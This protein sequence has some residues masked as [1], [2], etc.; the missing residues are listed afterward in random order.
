MIG[1]F[2]LSI[3]IDGMGEF[4]IDLM[5]SVACLLYL[6]FLLLVVGSLCSVS[7]GFSS[8]ILD[9]RVRLVFCFI[10]FQRSGSGAKVTW[11]DY[12]NC[13]IA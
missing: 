8:V 1:V 4:W 5:V 2:G 11:D 9:R 10:G 13:W 6:C 12:G 3:P 7:V